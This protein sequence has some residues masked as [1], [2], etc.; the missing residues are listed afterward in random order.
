M[1]HINSTL[2]F[3]T[4]ENATLQQQISKMQG[5]LEEAH[6]IR[7][8]IQGDFERIRTKVEMAQRWEEECKRLKRKAEFVC[9]HLHTLHQ[10]HNKLSLQA[11]NQLHNIKFKF[12]NN[13]RIKDQ[14][15][16]DRLDQIQKEYEEMQQI[17]SR[18]NHNQETQSKSGADVDLQLLEEEFAFML[19]KDR[20]GELRDAQIIELIGTV[21]EITNVLNFD[22]RH[23]ELK[24]T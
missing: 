11:F 6:G 15:N 7:G 1:E 20:R 5:E 21:S 10:K 22:L 16:F 17:S 14:V 24:D 12:Q 2:T 8:E 23:L 18:S 19:D 4:C 3:L 13:Q 9:D